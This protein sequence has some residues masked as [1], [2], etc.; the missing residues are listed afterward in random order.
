VPELSDTADINE[1]ISQARKLFGSMRKQLLGNKQIPIDI[2]ERISQ[3]R[4]LFGSMRKQ[5][6]GN[7]Q[8]PIDINERI[9]QARKLFGSMRKQLLGSKQIPIDIRGRLFQATVVNIALW[10]CESWALREADRSK[11]EAFHHGCLRKMRGWTT[12]DVTEKRITN[13]RVRRT[14]A[15]KWKCKDADGFANSA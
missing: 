6:L 14:V 11:L 12:W 7:K 5:L 2:N 13:E 10:G 1:R 9:S 15:W 4:K 8:I 3:A